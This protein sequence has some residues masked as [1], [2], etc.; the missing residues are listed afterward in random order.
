[1]DLN[2]LTRLSPDGLKRV[3]PAFLS[4]FIAQNQEQTRVLLDA[5]VDSWT[6]EETHA[7]HEG[8][9][10]SVTAGEVQH[11]LPPCQDVSRRWSDAVV[12][13]SSLSGIEHLEQAFATGPTVILSNHLSYFDATAT[14]AILAAHSPELANRIVFAAGPKVYQSLFRRVAAAGLN[15]LPVPQSSRLSHT[16]NLPPREFARLIHA[17]LDAAKS[18]LAQEHALLV[19]PEG[20]RSRSGRL[21]PF[22]A[23][24]HRYLNLKGLQVVPL[25]IVGTQAIM[26]VGTKSIRPGPVSLSFSAPIT[27][28]GDTP[29]K[30]AL[31]LAYTRIVQQLPASHRPSGGQ[32]P[33][34]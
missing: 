2:S 29:S 3:L 8:L 1:M 4:G 19:Y 16:E 14:D 5:L 28:D 23:G 7:V 11:T 27:I 13:R 25:A 9:G 17:S 6:S 34:A 33:I 20:S 18:L 21:S 12:T 22:I 24:V 15:T 10:R 26:P 32:V 31:E 30:H